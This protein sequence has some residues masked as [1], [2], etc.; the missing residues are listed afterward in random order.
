MVFSTAF[1]SIPESIQEVIRILMKA[2]P[3]EIILFGSRA[4]GTFRK[5]SDFDI[6]VKNKSCDENTWN[7]LLS[8]IQENPVTLYSVD[9]VEY[10][11]LLQP[12]KN[13]IDKEGITLWIR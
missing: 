3:Q 6:A 11:K 9:I 7:S 8:D 1:N 10:E 4:R 5:N 2:Q 13:Q 12:Y